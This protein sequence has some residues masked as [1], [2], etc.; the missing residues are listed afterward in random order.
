IRAVIMEK[1]AAFGDNAAGELEHVFRAAGP[2]FDCAR[3]FVVWRYAAEQGTFGRKIS[4]DVIMKNDCLRGE[5]ARVGAGEGEKERVVRLNLDKCRAA[6]SAE[7]VKQFKGPGAE[8][9]QKI[10]LEK[11]RLF[12]PW[13]CDCD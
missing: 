2:L 4:S 3:D 7:S 8:F 10:K 1:K 9:G 13:A 12:F 11:R 5:V 6:C